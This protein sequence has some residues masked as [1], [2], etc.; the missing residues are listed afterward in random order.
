[1]P[2]GTI[3]GDLIDETI[4]QLKANITELAND[5]S[6]TRVKKWM[7]TKRIQR[8]DFYAEVKAGPMEP[9]DGRTTRA[10]NNLF[11]VIIDLI[12]AATASEGFET[13][14]DTAM[15]VAQKVYD[16]FH[17]TN[18]MNGLV[19]QCLVSIFPGDGEL[20]GTLLSIPIRCTITCER[21]VVQT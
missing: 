19:R 8:G 15:G 17:I 18:N 21:V 16:L 4:T 5:G 6:E 7:G 3:F 14:F 13:G 11:T 20:S 12:Y 2:I 10:T 9:I 1:M